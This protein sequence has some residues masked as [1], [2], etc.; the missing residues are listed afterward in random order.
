ME[1]DHYRCYLTAF[2]I[3]ASTA[4][5]SSQT[6]TNL[7][8]AWK[9]QAAVAY[10]DRVLCV[11]LLSALQN[12]P[13]LSPSPG[14]RVQWEWD[15]LQ[16]KLTAQWKKNICFQQLFFYLLSRPCFCFFSL[17]LW[18][19]YECWCANADPQVWSLGTLHFFIQWQFESD[20]VHVTQFGS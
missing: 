12:T 20:S 13:P 14:L 15:L 9:F 8:A 16:R 2:S 11:L 18:Q 1:D 3:C 17:M 7:V 10:I 19:K 5:R 6:K 4:G